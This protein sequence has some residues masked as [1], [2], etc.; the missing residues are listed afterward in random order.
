MADTVQIGSTGHTAKVRHPVAV[1]IFSFITLGI[2]FVY[3]WYQVNREVVDLGRARNV[4]GLGDNPTVSALA[5]FPGVLVI[6]PPYVSL[7]NGVKRFQRAQQATLEDSTLNGWI[8]LALIV[9]GLFTVFAAAIV[10]GYIQAELNKIWETQPRVGIEA[11]AGDSDLDRIKKLAELKDTGA[12]SAEEFETEK[13]RV[14][15]HPTQGSPTE[16]S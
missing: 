6:V 16:E 2:Y 13:A 9:A 3:W 1:S 7:Y 8:V 5:I 15:R 12:I 4:A 10:P 11:A 14:L